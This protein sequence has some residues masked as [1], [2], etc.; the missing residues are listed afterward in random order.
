M[1]TPSLFLHADLAPLPGVVAPI[2][3]Q[4]YKNPR[5]VIR[6][7]ELPVLDDFHVRVE[8]L[9]AGICGTDL[10]LAQ[11]NPDT[12]YI[13]C[14]APVEIPPEGRLIG[15]EGVGKAIAVGRHVS[16]IKPG[17]HLTFESILACQRC[18]RCR[19]GDFNQCRESRLLG[20][21]EDGLFS[22]VADVPASVAHTI[23]D[24]RNGSDLATLACL[25]PAAVAYLAC[26]NAR[27]R[28][29][30]KVVVFGGGPI[31][32]YSAIAARCIFG[33]SRIYVVDPI[34]YRRQLAREWCDHSLDVEEFFEAPPSE[35]D[36]V[37]ES[38]G[39]LE[40]LNRVFPRIN[41]NGRAVLLGRCGQPLRIDALDH[42][43][44]NAI[45]IV[46]SRGHLGGAFNDLLTLHRSGKFPLGAP[47][48]EII[49]GLD[50]LQDYLLNPEKVLNE[51]CKVL[52]KFAGD[53]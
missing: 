39:I 53:E 33:A 14:S 24:Y 2:P 22:R 7:R 23:N 21:E 20:L 18:V 16:H 27:V 44:T 31:G 19:R 8:M 6:E 52:V 46:G 43:I 51:N 45:S 1:I 12:G 32:L 29:A 34:P 26:Q 42:M 37:I 30:D 48:T 36:V 15:H 38:S 35:I 5:L 10:H 50:N 49:D 17:D 41:A 28:G 47:I 40:N 3:P 13:R 11:R 25:E 4:K 9:Y